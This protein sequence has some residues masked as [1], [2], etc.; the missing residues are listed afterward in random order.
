MGIGPF[1]NYGLNYSTPEEIG[2][3]P[4]MIFCP[5]SSDSVVDKHNNNNIYRRN[6]SN[7]KPTTI[8]SSQEVY[9]DLMSLQVIPPSEL[10]FL[11]WCLNYK[12][13]ALLGLGDQQMQQQQQQPYNNLAVAAAP[14]PAFDL[15]ARRFANLGDWYESRARTLSK[16]IWELDQIH[17]SISRAN[18]G[19]TF[20]KCYQS[21]VNYA[22]AL[23]IATAYD[24]YKELT[25]GTHGPNWS[26]EKPMDYQVFRQKLA[27]QML[28]YDQKRS[29]TQLM[30]CFVRI[31]RVQSTSSQELTGGSV[32]ATPLTMWHSVRLCYACGKPCYYMCSKCKDSKLDITLYSVKDNHRCLQ[33]YHDHR[34]FGLLKGDEYMEYWV[35]GKNKKNEGEGAKEQSSISITE[36]TA[37]LISAIATV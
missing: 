15:Q 16:N 10:Y 17:S 37:N 13:C 11:L 26:I 6:N 24:V 36:L 29:Y 4:D 14:A 18:I 8:C 5:S 2:C 27:E 32:A 9:K 30:S 1:S 28:Q 23:S 12:H 25:N 7:N 34:F 22:K 19:Y 35:F 3:S 31:F 33:Q 20:W 21:A